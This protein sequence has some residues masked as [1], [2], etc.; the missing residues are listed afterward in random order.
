MEK[1]EKY[2]AKKTNQKKSIGIW[3]FVQLF[4]SQLFEQNKKK[5]TNKI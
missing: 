4:Y 1:K 2:I 3:R 5:D